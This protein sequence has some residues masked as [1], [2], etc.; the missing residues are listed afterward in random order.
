MER[1]RST[2]PALATKRTAR[3]AL[4]H[5]EL[6]TRCGLHPPSQTRTTAAPP[7]HCAL[8]AAR[9]TPP[10]PTT[11]RAAERRPSE[12]R[13]IPARPLIANEDESSTPS[14]RTDRGPQNSTVANTSESITLTVAASRPT[15][16]KSQIREQQPTAAHLHHR[17]LRAPAA[18]LHP[19]H[20]QQPPAAPPR[21]REDIFERPSSPIAR[22][23][24][25]SSTIPSSRAGSRTSGAPA[26]SAAAASGAASSLRGT[27]AGAAARMP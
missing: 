22:A 17:A 19:P 13:G 15:A 10:S 6:A 18:G 8:A 24:A 5:Y 9:G 27:G 2:A 1:A 23:T 25:A 21:H 3:A 14:S 26:P 16:A 7:H 12:P 20:Q 11:T 4:H